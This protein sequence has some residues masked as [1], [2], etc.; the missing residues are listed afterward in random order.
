MQIDLTGETL[1]PNGQSS[2]PTPEPMAAMN[3]MDK[4]HE[5]LYSSPIAAAV[6]RA[7]GS[8]LDVAVALGA[9]CEVL[10]KRIMEMEACAPRVVVLKDGKRLVWHCPDHLIPES[11]VTR[12]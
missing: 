10:G 5:L 4:Y 1:H 3:R 11:R 6:V 8:A 9:Q 2:M 12:L 7:G